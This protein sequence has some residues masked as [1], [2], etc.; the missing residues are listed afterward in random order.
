MECG[1]DNEVLKTYCFWVRKVFCYPGSFF[2]YFFFVCLLFFPLILSLS[3]SLFSSSF[4]FFLL[5]LPYFISCKMKVGLEMFCFV[6]VR[7]TKQERRA[8]QT[9]SL[10]ESLRAI[11]TQTSSH[12]GP[13]KSTEGFPWTSVKAKSVSLH[14]VQVKTI[15]DCTSVL[16]RG[17]WCSPLLGYFLRSSVALW[18]DI[19]GYWTLC[20]YNVTFFFFSW[21]A[22]K[23]HI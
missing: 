3:L 11:Q 12:L 2:F 10:S 14:C 1:G 17:V 16:Q 8:N 13:Q 20:I 23:C 18:C 22:K 4:F 7:K 21:N 15:N 6:L 5:F 9:N 19:T